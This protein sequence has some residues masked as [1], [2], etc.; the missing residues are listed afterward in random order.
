MP[1]DHQ[2][3]PLPITVSDEERLAR[4]VFHPYHINNSGKVKPAAFKARTGARDVSVNR[5]RALDAAACKQ[6][7]RAIA[8]PGAFRGFAVLGAA[9]I[10]KCRYSDVVDSRRHYW[11]HAD[12]IHQVVLEKGIPAPPEF[13]QCLKQMAQDAEYFSDSTPE[14]D[15]W[16]GTAFSDD[17]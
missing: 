16:T 10:R 11:G 8:N 13:N 5:L 15:T 3:E 1:Q 2:Q 7:A 6:R 12:I 4:A 9:S 17:T 14:S